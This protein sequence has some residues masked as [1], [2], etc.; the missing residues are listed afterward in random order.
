MFELVQQY[1]TLQCGLICFL[2]FYMNAPRFSRQKTSNLRSDKEVHPVDALWQNSL[3][4]RMC[5]ERCFKKLQGSESN[6]MAEKADM[7]Q[8]DREQLLRAMLFMYHE[9]K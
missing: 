1:C 3:W 4:L 5:L 7:N 6:K 8:H 2:V 9:H